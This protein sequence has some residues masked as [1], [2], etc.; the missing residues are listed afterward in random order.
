MSALLRALAGLLGE[1]AAWCAAVVVIAAV[2][3]LA[4]MAALRAAGHPGTVIVAA[5]VGGALS[6]GIADRIGAPE[7]WQIGLSV[8]PVAVAWAAAGAAIAAA[9]VCVR[10]RARGSS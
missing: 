5:A 6:V 1:T 9:V 10:N 4:V 7:L 2:V 8:R 3:S